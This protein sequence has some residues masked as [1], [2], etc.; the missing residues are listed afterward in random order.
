MQVSSFR[1]MSSMVWQAR[2]GGYDIP[3]FG[4]VWD[5]KQARCPEGKT[6]IYWLPFVTQPCERDVVKIRFA[7]RDCSP[8]PQRER[9][10]RSPTGQPRS[11]IV[12]DQ[13]S[14]HAL[15]QTRH[16]LTT[17]QGQ[18]EYRLRTGVEGTLSQA[19]R[20]S[21]LRQTR[22]RGL[23]KTHLQHVATAVALNVL[24]CVEHLCHKPLAQT[25][26]TRFAR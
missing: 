15:E 17:V 25:R 16:R 5:N 24:R 3:L 12:P 13:V 11:L 6:S 26:S 14:F 9:C 20:R 18:S 8:C 2:E 22:Y 1:V 23:A 4:I 10:V 19:V 21:G 7:H